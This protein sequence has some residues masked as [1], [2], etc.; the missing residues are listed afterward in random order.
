MAAVSVAIPLDVLGERLLAGLAE[1]ALLADGLVTANGESVPDGGRGQVVIMDRAGN[2]YRVV[3]R[4]D[5]P[6]HSVLIDHQEGVCLVDGVVREP[7]DRQLELLSLLHQV[8]PKAVPATWLAEH[9]W[10]GSGLGMAN[11]VNLAYRLDV[12]LG[13]KGLIAG[14]GGFYWLDLSAPG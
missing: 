8:C 14:R 9:F 5:L 2:C 12:A 10:P 13:D 1:A 3:H 7:T 4:C 6:T 11:L